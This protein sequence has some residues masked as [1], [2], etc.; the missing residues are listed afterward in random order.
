M[1]HGTVLLVEDD[2]AVAQFMTMALRLWEYEV[3]HAAT[4]RQALASASLHR[5]DISLIVCDV[6]LQGETGPAVAARIRGIC[7]QSRTLFTSG[8]SIDLLHESGLLSREALQNS[9]TGFIQ[10]PFVLT[11]LGTAINLLS[12]PAHEGSFSA[13]HAGVRHAG[14]AY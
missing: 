7:P 3:V 1:H 5:N 12:Q 13:P 14:A 10:K 11:E 8:F 6:N 2:P 4:S 9:H